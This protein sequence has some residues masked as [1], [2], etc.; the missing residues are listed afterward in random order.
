MGHSSIQVRWDRD[1]DLY[2]DSE[3]D[4]RDLLNACI[5]GRRIHGRTHDNEEPHA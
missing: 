4:E 1:G 2:R 5:A 3:D